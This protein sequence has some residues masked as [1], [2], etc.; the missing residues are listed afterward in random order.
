MQ[1]RGRSLHRV[2]QRLSPGGEPDEPGALVIRVGLAGEVAVALQVS[3]ELVHRLLGHRRADRQ[4]GDPA[5]LN[6]AEAE[7]LQVSGAQLW[8]P[9]G[10]MAGDVG[11]RQ[12]EGEADDTRY[13]ARP[14]PL[15][16]CE[17]GCIRHFRQATLPLGS[18]A[19]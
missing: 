19:A 6:G 17:P 7:D 2:L 14:R 5:A 10:D 13:A 18:Q 1:A 12:L 9:A 16:A 8:V 15:W 11:D 4:V 3:D